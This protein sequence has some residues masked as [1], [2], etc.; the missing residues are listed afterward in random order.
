MSALVFADQAGHTNMTYNINIISG[1][2]KGQIEATTIIEAAHLA[3]AGDF[4]GELRCEPI[5]TTRGAGTT[6]SPI[7]ERDIDKGGIWKVF[8]NANRV[9]TMIIRPAK[10]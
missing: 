3:A 4:G 1:G 6:N 10:R 8:R 7:V 9:G 5:I 2:T